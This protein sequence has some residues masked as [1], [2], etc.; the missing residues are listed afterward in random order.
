V[1]YG[2]SELQARFSR[3]QP[4]LVPRRM[5]EAGVFQCQ[6]V[7]AQ[8]DRGLRAV[9]FVRCADHFDEAALHVITGECAMTF[10]SALSVMP[11]VNAGRLR[12]VAVTT[13]KRDATLPQVPAIA[14]TIP[15]Y[16][17][18]PWYGVFVPA[19]TPPGIVNKLHAEFS[20][21][22]RAPDI[23]QRLAADGSTVAS[24]GPEAFAKTILLERARAGRRWCR[25]LAS[26]QSDEKARQP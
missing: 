8:S 2:S 25:P 21:I 26:G 15:G 22:V 5:L 23:A 12:A 10:T 18:S 17:V 24:H 20:R 3:Q 19:G 4:E 1:Y 13:P 9:A 11:H 14:E 6:V 16:D 7:G